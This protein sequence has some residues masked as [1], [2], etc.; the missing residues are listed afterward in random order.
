MERNSSESPFPAERFAEE[1]VGEWRELSGL[2]DIARGKPGRL[3]SEDL[4]RLGELYRHAAADLSRARLLGLDRETLAYLNGLVARA[5]ALIYRHPKRRTQTVLRFF[6]REFP[7][8]FRKRLSYVIVSAVVFF[9]STALAYISVWANERNAYRLVPAS[10][11]VSP[12]DLERKGPDRATVPEVFRPMFASAIVTNNVQVTF[13]AFA[14]GITC[15]IGTAYVMVTNGLLLG[16]LSA[17]FARHGTA[18]HFWGLILPHGVIELSAV[19]IAGGA[20]LLLGRAVVFPGHR[21]RREALHLYGLDAVKLILGCVPL[22]VVAGCIEGF[23]TPAALPL[24]LK[25]GV[26]VGS[27]VVLAAYLF[28]CGAGEAPRGREARSRALR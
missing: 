20:G 1:R 15:G 2:L 23:I 26:G 21:S 19:V 12:D 6:T 3:S 24:W 10:C 8:L 9:S 22:L 11:V 5:H 27:G 28:R 18:L 16:A 4:S 7:R 25:Y 17:L 14:L 13:F